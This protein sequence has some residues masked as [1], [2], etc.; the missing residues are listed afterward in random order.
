[1]ITFYENQVAARQAASTQGWRE[2]ALCFVV[3]GNQLLV[4]EHV[5]DGGAGVQVVA[6]G[7]ELGEAPEQAAIRELLEESG[8]RLESP[9][10]LVSYRWE[11]QLP[12]RF[13]CQVCHAYAFTAPGHLPDT[14]EQHAD[15][16]LFRFRWADIKQPGL[17]W[18]M[19]AALPA[20]KE[21]I[22]AV[23]D[24]SHPE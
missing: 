21:A 1:M 3:R 17:D 4:F 15:N 22:Q 19:D 24:V 23:L 8:L 7:V 9:L 6:G 20:L 5:P 18:E 13:T 12:E 14:W 2:K 10:H 16:H 11:A